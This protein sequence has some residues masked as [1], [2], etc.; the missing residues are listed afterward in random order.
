MIRISG[1]KPDEYTFEWFIGTDYADIDY[2]IYVDVSAKAP[3]TRLREAQEARELLALQGQYGG[4][5]GTSIITPQEAI[6]KMDITD[7]DKIIQRMNMEE[8]RNKTEEAM[9]VA[10][11]MME[12]LQ[13]GVPP[14][15]VMQMGMAMFQQME[16]QMK[17]LGS[18]NSNSFQMQ[19]GA[20]SF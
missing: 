3:V 8:L 4:Q 6:E 1:T 19:Q 14:E 16:D 17:G 11:M 9:Q 13:G 7:K 18:T 2:D 15:E 10:Q 5:F 12:A 20:P